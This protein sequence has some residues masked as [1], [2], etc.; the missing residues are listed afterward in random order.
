M[1]QPHEKP[2]QTKGRPPIESNQTKKVL[3]QRKKKE[4]G[5]TLFWG[6]DTRGPAQACHNSEFKVFLT[7]KKFLVASHKHIIKMQPKG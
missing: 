2:K 3:N 4:K 1:L 5:H 6:N 7:P